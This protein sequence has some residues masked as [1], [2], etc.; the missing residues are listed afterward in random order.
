[1]TSCAAS[2]ILWERIVVQRILDPTATA[3]QVY[4]NICDDSGIDWEALRRF[5][6]E[7]DPVNW[8]RIKAHWK[9][10]TV[11]RIVM[12]DEPPVA[13]RDRRR[14]PK[15]VVLRSVVK[16]GLRFLRRSINSLTRLSM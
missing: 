6:E 16:H 15:R 8:Q 5:E 7:R 13:H 10:H 4:H 1:M 3:I 2:Y 9:F 14:R 11:V 12:D